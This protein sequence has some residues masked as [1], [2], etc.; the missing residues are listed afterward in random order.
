MSLGKIGTLVVY[1]K[2]TLYERISCMLSVNIIS[3]YLNTNIQMIWD[4]DVPYHVLFL[5][6]IGLVKFEYFSNKNYIYNPNIN[7]SALLNTIIP[8][9]YSDMHWIIDTKEELIHKDMSLAEYE[10]RKKK[11]YESLLKN[12][13]NGMLLGQL[14]LF[15][16]P[17]KPFYFIDNLTNTQE[18][19]KLKALPMMSSIEFPDAKNAELQEYLQILIYSKATC[20]VC[21]EQT[22]PDIFKKAC[23]IY[24]IPIICLNKEC[25]NN[26]NNELLLKSSCENYMGYP[27]VINPDLVKIALFR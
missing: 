26:I 2:G 27:L 25:K 17:N 4:H 23:Q 16:L 12:N 9:K 14:N 10:I 5:N 21:T 1:P 3:N 24:F 8:D 20:L 6:D 11:L 22:I 7:Q 15:E 19:S 13:I 18:N